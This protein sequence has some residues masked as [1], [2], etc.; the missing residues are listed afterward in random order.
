MRNQNT[1]KMF[2]DKLFLN[3]SSITSKRIRYALPIFCV[4]K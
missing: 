2:I 1:N 3:C 4:A